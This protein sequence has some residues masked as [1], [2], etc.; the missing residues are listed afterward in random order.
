MAICGE[1]PILKTSLLHHILKKDLQARAG[2]PATN[3]D[4][5]VWPNLPIAVLKCMSCPFLFDSALS[6][7]AIELGGWT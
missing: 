6:L 1:W 2:I 5:D 7:N 3:E 4:G